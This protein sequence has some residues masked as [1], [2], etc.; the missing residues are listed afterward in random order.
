MFITEKANL[1]IRILYSLFNKKSR[2]NTENKVLLYKVAVN[3]FLRL[4]TCNYL[5]LIAGI[6]KCPSNANH[7]IM[8]VITDV[9]DRKEQRYVKQIYN[10][11]HILLLTS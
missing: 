9:G 4:V 1:A 7:S 8:E 6:A 11:T 2:L 3:S 10:A 5:N